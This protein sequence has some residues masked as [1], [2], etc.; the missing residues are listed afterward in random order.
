MKKLFL[1]GLVFVII[2][3][4]LGSYLFN[5]KINFLNITNQNKYYFI[6]DKS[7]NNYLGITKDLEIAEV[8]ENIYLTQGI[9]C[10][11]IEKKLVSKKLNHSISELDR[12]VKTA[13]KEKDILLIEEIV[14]AN[15]QKSRSKN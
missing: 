13:K 11:V 3:Y 1:V 8:I 2:G 12:L 7:T 9:K 10:S 14:V 6:K 5:I 15:Y 4:F